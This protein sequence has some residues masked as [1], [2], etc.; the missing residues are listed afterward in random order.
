[1]Q[2]VAA[3]AAAVDEQRRPTSHVSVVVYLHRVWRHRPLRYVLLVATLMQGHLV[4]GLMEKIAL[5][6]R[7]AGVQKL[8]HLDARDAYAQLEALVLHHVQRQYSQTVC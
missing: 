8:R 3:D 1:L 2:Q 5:N 6:V 4:T 7:R